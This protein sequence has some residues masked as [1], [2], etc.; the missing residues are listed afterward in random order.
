MERFEEA[1][2]KIKTIDATKTSNDE[3]LV[4]K[5]FPFP[6]GVIVYIVRASGTK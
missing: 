5:A 6:C 1:A 4:R 3:K 2:E